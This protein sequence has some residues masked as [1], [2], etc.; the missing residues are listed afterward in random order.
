LDHPGQLAK[1]VWRNQHASTP[2]LMNDD[3]T[4]SFAERFAN[5]LYEM[6]W[7]LF[8]ATGVWLLV[9]LFP[10]YK[11]FRSRALLLL[12]IATALGAF[13]TIFD[14]NY[15]K[16]VRPG[17]DDVWTYFALRE[18]LWFASTII[19]TVGLLMFAWDYERLAARADGE[20]IGTVP[21]PPVV[22]RSDDRERTP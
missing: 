13:I 10:V 12:V 18:V 8:V 7:I 5:G 19:Y 1:A 4:K 2:I 20:P 21:T 16:F 6:E 22:P 3:A 14:Q 15:L 9:Y 17:I 11:R